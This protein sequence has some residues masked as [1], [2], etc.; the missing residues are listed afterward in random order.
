MWRLVPFGLL[1]S[2]LVAAFRFASGVSKAVTGDSQHVL[3]EALAKAG[4]EGEES[5]ESQV[6]PSSCRNDNY[7]GNEA[8]LYDRECDH[9]RDCPHEWAY[10]SEPSKHF[11]FSLVVEP[12]LASSQP[13]EDAQ[14]FTDPAGNNADAINRRDV[15]PQK[16]GAPYGTKGRQHSRPDPH[17]GRILHL[18]GSLCLLL[19]ALLR[20]S[21]QRTKGSEFG[22][23][24]L[25]WL[26][27]GRP[28]SVSP[29]LK[30]D[31]RVY[32]GD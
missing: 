15:L 2:G 19:E 9:S 32:L 29:I 3:K 17:P 11:G 6:R 16:A 5:D 23:Q 12:E 27:V 30:R 25:A 24:L 28:G 13:L 21:D 4:E 8:R 31:G 7:A 26:I 10:A 20:A 14:A 18:S 22:L 1:A